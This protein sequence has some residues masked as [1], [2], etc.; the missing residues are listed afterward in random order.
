MNLNRVFAMRLS[1]LLNERKMSKYR[2][3]QETGLSHSA[4]RYI[5]NEIN[6]DVKFSTIVKVCQAL[7]LPLTDFFDDKSF[8]LENLNAENN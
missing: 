7:N 5:F 1:A 2:L 6:A 8:N 4:L 3:E